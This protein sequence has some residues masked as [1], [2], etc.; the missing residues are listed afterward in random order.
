VGVEPTL[1]VTT[2]HWTLLSIVFSITVLTPCPLESP[3]HGHTFGH[4]RGFVL[5]RRPIAPR[6]AL[7]KH[8]LEISAA[9]E[10]AR[11]DE[12]QGPGAQ[13]HRLGYGLREPGREHLEGMARAGRRSNERFDRRLPKTRYEG[14][15]R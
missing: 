13:S 10:R 14:C 8:S 12:R 9:A 15:G 2:G 4:T 6:T 5:R 1:E 3:Q 7:R 11:H